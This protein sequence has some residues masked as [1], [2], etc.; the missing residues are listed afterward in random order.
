[1]MGYLSGLYTSE[2]ILKNY[3]IKLPELKAR[4]SIFAQLYNDID[5]MG[6]D[7]LKKRLIAKFKAIKEKKFRENAEFA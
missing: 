6:E 2:C 4:A 1:M 7:E 3:G 5:N